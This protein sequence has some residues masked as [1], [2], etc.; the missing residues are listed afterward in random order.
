MM[1]QYLHGPRVYRPHRGRRQQRRHSHCHHR[2]PH[3]QRLHRRHHHRCLS[4]RRP[5]DRR[6]SR[7]RPR[8]DRT[9]CHRR[10][11]RS[12]AEACLLPAAAL[13]AALAVADRLRRHCVS[14]VSRCHPSH[15]RPCRQRLSSCAAYPRVRGAG[16]RPSNQQHFGRENFH[17]RPEK[18]QPS[19]SARL[20]YMLNAR[21]SYS[22]LVKRATLWL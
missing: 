1:V 7:Y 12:Q 13:A 17:T 15:P 16:R 8:C 22:M 19:Y 2:L 6:S 14:R 9:R 21:L 5:N 20:N 18:K 11:V 3:R 10:R 4:L